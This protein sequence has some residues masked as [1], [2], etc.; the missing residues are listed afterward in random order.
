MGA[1]CTKT[2]NDDKLFVDDDEKKIL[3]SLG[4]SKAI[5]NKRE[6]T[7]LKK[8]C[9]RRNISQ[10]N[11]NIIYKKFLTDPEGI[12]LWSYE[13]LIYSWD[14]NAISQPQFISELSK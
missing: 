4:F 10:H 6:W 13:V 7:A 3:G 14:I 5:F 2:Q 12:N 1:V 9:N 8:F 11:L